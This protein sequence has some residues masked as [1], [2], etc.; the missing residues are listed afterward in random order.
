LPEKAF[1]PTALAPQPTPSLQAYTLYLQGRF[2]ALKRNPEGL[3]VAVEYLEQ[4]IEHDATFALAHAALGEAWA[5]RGFEAFGDL[6]LRE[7]MPR[8]REHVRRALRLDPSLAEAHTWDAVITFLYDWNWPAADA[9]FRHA[10]ELKPA[11]SFSHTWYAVF[12]WAMG[13][14]DEAIARALHAAELDPMSL[15]IQVV[16]ACTYYMAR[17]WEQAI[18]RLRPIVE[19]D[20]GNIRATHWLGRTLMLSGR[21]EEAIAVVEQGMARQGR[22]P[23]QLMLLGA[24]RAEQGRERDAHAVLDE[25]QQLRAIRHV[26]AAMDAAIYRELGMLDAAMD[27]YERLYEERSGFLVFNAVE[28]ALDKLRGHPRFQSLLRRLKLDR[29][30]AI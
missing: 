2:H 26:S 6:P 22:T 16:V 20:P 19:L 9:A 5:L 28:P 23:H 30:P 1:L 21:T 29:L 3:R 13:R 27:C 18:A 24:A 11:Y 7:A 15:T 10:L 4:A 8:A 17:R 25:L 12:L 14:V